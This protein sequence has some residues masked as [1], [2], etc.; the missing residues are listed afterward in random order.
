MF[1]FV[2]SFHK[3]SH[4][5]EFL[6]IH[7]IE[8]SYLLPKMLMNESFIQSLN[9]IY[10]THIIIQKKEVM[11]AKMKASAFSLTEAKYVAGD[12][13]QSVIENAEQPTMKIRSRTDNVAGV[14]LPVFEPL[15]EGVNSQAMAGLAKGGHQIQS[16]RVSFQSALEVLVS[17]A[18]LQT[19]YKTLDAVIKITNRRVNALEHVV[20]PRIEATLSYIHG[21]LD[22]MEREEY[23]RLKLIQK[24][25]KRD[26]EKKAADKLSEQVESLSLAAPD[27][28]FIDPSSSLLDQ[29]V[30]QDVDVIF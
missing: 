17:L 3:I 7:N 6:S 23:F 8:V 30:G 2:I 11:G 27:S 14:K 28:G 10:C 1:R 5:I 21:E 19:S 13:S 9:C 16:C 24:K 18:S 20:I 22:E 4:H 25:K 12:F 26:H 29:Y 15:Y